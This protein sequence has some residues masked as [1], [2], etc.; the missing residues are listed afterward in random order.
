MKKIILLSLVCLIVFALPANA[1][2]S[3]KA[4]YVTPTTNLDNEYLYNALINEGFTVTISDIIPPTM[5]EY[6]LVVVASYAAAWQITA[7]YMKD[8]VANGGGTVIL[9]GVPASFPYS[10]I[11]HSLSQGYFDI[12]YISAWF[13]TPYYR[14]VA[15]SQALISMENPFGTDLQIGD[16]IGYSN[17]W[18]GAAVAISPSADTQILAEWTSYPGYASAFTHSYLDGRVFYQATMD[19]SENSHKLILA[20]ALWAANVPSNNPPTADPN[21]PYTGDEGSIITFDGSGSYDPDVDDLIVLYEWDLDNDGSFDD[22]TGEYPTAT[23]NDD[24]SGIVSLKVTDSYGATDTASTTVTVNNVNPSVD[25]LTMPMEPIQI[26]TQITIGGKFSDL[27]ILDTHTAVWNWGDGTTSPGIVDEIPGS[28]SVTGNHVY[29]TPGVYTVTL[30]V[31]DDNSGVGTLESMTYIVIYDPSI[32]F[33]T[34]GGWINSPEGAFSSDSSLTGKVNFGFVSKYKKGATIPTGQTQ[35]QFTVADLN[36]HSDSYKWLVI[37]NAKA[38]YKGTGSING[39]VSPNG[40]PYKFLLSAIDADV[41]D[42]DA[43]E[44]DMFR[45]KIYYED[46]NG[47][48]VVYDNHADAGDDAEPTTEIL[49]GSITIHSGK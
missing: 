48:V 15:V 49:G 44:I 23:W 39:D 14:N 34:G 28:G 21:G 16:Q 27:G 1:E 18:G 38:M 24:Y 9:S 33:V 32:G 13:G 40:E 45:I 5:E 29:G 25:T 43:F 6:D 30:T 47:E 42:V 4:L 22:A 26:S 10:Y 41:N 12:S 36:F 31:T 19:G 37:A 17:A 46:I 11:P 20:G 8:Y 35:F 3:P 2:Y 7:D